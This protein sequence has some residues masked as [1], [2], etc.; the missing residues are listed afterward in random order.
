V[1]PLSA[2]A[3]STRK[4]NSMDYDAYKL[5]LD[6]D[7]EREANAI[8]AHRFM[9]PRRGP[10]RGDARRKGLVRGCDAGKRR[11]TP[12]QA[13]FAVKASH[14]VSVLKPLRLRGYTLCES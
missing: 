1:V 14:G 12:I 8:L 4:G 7:A 2:R 6:F 5:S 9:T 11:V 10:T 13:S 3:V